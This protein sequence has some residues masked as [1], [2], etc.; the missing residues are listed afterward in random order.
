M[1]PA[2]EGTPPL[3]LDQKNLW[4]Q[5]DHLDFD[6]LAQSPSSALIDQPAS[7]FE[8]GEA[9]LLPHAPFGGCQEKALGRLPQQMKNLLCRLFQGCRDRPDRHDE[10]D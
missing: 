3:F 4:F 10:L 6:G 9:S 8:I 7:P 1:R 2:S 5:F